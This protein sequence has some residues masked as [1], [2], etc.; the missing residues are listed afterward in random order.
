MIILYPNE[1]FKEFQLPHKLR[2]RYAVSNYGRI[3]SFVKNIEDGNLLRGSD[4]DGYRVMRYK[5]FESGVIKNHH[6]FVYKLVAELFIEKENPLQDRVI[7]LDYVRDNDVYTNLK[8]VTQEEQLLH[9]KNSPHVKEA[10]KNLLENK[11]RFQ[12]AKLTST[13]VIRLKKQ[14]NKPD[15]KTRLRLI[16]KQFNIS[17]TQLNRIRKG[18]NWSHIKI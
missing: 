6:V 9:H 10:L 12:G 3:M 16:A 15:R 2:K 17:E 18:E 5:T 13:D 11:D 7:H 1:I 14:L 4:A 8:W